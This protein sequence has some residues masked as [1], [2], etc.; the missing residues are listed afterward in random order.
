MLDFLN[1]IN[2]F[3]RCHRIWAVATIVKYERDIQ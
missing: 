1:N 2:F 3:H